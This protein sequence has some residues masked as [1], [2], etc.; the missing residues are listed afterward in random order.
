MITW[1]HNGQPVKVKTGHTFDFIELTLEKIT[2][3]I[4]LKIEVGRGKQKS[5][6]VKLNRL[7]LVDKTGTRYNTYLKHV[8]VILPPFMVPTKNIYQLMHIEE[9]DFVDETNSKAS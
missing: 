3:H 8:E 1:K 5:V 4:E 7:T 6:F 2:R 9:S